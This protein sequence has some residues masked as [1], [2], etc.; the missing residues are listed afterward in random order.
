MA[1]STGNKNQKSWWQKLKRIFLWMVIGQFVYILLLWFINPPITITQMVDV[2]KG[3][4]L[5]KDN[6]SYEAMGPNIKLAVLAAEDQ[7]FPDHNG[8]DIK[9]IKKAQKY[10]QKHPNKV[11]GASTISQQTAKNIF[12]WQGGGWFRKGLEVYFTF[13]I[14]TLYSKERILQHY[15]NV[16]EMGP[17]IFGVQAAAK[18]Y[19]NKDAKNLSRSEAAMIAACLRNPKKYTVKPLS[20]FVSAVSG[21]ILRQMNNIETDPD[22][23]ALLK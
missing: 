14:E 4:G 23:A 3:Y 20:K 12:L 2:V 13:M 9:A 22:I 5:K 1:K 18:E 8:F 21:K 10:N 19:F 16:A 17:G 6:I 7:L 11:R 15:L